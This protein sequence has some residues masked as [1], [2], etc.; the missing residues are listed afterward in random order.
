MSTRC[1]QANIHPFVRFSDTESLLS[2]ALPLK[3]HISPHAQLQ[4]QAGLLVP[5]LLSPFDVL[6]AA[7]GSWLSTAPGFIHSGSSHS[8]CRR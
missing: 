2:C 5:T 3:Q 8:C 1:D 6:F 4:A 7:Y